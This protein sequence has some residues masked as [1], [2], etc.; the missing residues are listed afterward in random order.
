M[1][2]RNQP[3]RGYLKFQL[4]TLFDVQTSFAKVTKHAGKPFEDGGRPHLVGTTGSRVVSG[5]LYG[6]TKLHPRRGLQM[7]MGCRM[8]GISFKCYVTGYSPFYG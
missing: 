6:S 2:N 3:A 5:V 1:D 8:V 4:P 7:K